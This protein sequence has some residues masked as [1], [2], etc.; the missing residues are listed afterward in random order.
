[1]K[2]RLLTLFSGIVCM[3]FSVCAS[4]RSVAQTAPGNPAANITGISSYP[5]L[6]NN[7]SYGMQS[8]YDR[9]GGN[10]DGF[11]GK[12]SVLRHE[13]GN[14]VIAEIPGA[15]MI[16]RIWFPVDKDYP[17][18]PLGLRDKKIFIYINGKDKPV[19][20]MPL[21]TM[22]NNS[23]AHFPY[24]LCGMQLGGCW[25]YIPIAFHNGARV[26][27]EGDKA[28]FLHVEYNNYT[29]SANYPDF[30]LAKSPYTTAPSNLMN[31]LW[32]P[33]DIS[34]LAGNNLQ[35]SIITYHLKP[36]INTLNFPGGPCM[37]RGMIIKG[38]QEDLNVLFNGKLTINWDGENAAAI[39]T[40]LDMF[41]NHESTGLN[42]KSLLAGQLYGGEGVYNFFP[43]PYKWR[44]AVKVAVKHS[45][46]VTV[47]LAFQK[48][49]SYNNMYGYLHIQ[50]QKNAP[51]V[52]GKKFVWLDVDGHGKFVGIYM[53]AAGKS[54]SD[55]S[56][57][58]IY[59]TG[60]LEGDEVFEADG[61]MVE[62]GTGTED[63]FD[64]GW[65]G[66]HGKLDHAQCFPL[67]GFTLFDAAKDS[68]RM[69]AYRWRLP[70]DVVPFNQHFKAGI[71]VGPT[72]NE[73]GNYESIA[74]YY[75]SKP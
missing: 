45:C 72:D 20:D 44:A 64:A 63:Y 40:P 13:N 75:L 56:N 67:H 58:T 4:Y 52:P 14:S 59:W 54:L 19:V 21:V 29:N 3:L 36:G 10:D 8:S 34:Y 28:Y 43:M 15:G 74:Y 33:G 1:M 7:I 47:T 2:S 65:N 37:I 24:P 49:S 57:G 31:A 61:Q 51:T 42:D 46:T 71:E 12:W 41:F 73:A 68:S 23:D 53:R 30:D 35:T 66:M 18:V 32:N 55:S 38:S 48:L 62:H 69:A 16:T 50:H 26:V 27:I 70:S 22:F 60:C 25:S 17:D 11:G 39:N 6:T 5:V 9:S